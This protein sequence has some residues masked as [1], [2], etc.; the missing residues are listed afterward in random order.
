MA[1]NEKD[2]VCSQMVSC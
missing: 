2:A 1:L